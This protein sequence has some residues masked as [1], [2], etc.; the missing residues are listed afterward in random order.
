MILG[1]TAGLGHQIFSTMEATAAGLGR[2]E[3]PTYV[4][5]GEDDKLVPQAASLPLLDHPKV[6]YRSWP[7]LRH[8]CMNEPEKFEV[9]AEIN[10]WLVSQLNDTSGSAQQSA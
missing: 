7:G 9:L 10:Q 8:E 4:L 6:T 5:H 2:I 1:A 3:V